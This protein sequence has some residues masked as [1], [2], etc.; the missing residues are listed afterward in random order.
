[1]RPALALLCLATMARAQTASS[2]PAGKWVSNLKFF[3]ENN[4]ERMELNLGGTRL[5]G[6]IGDHVFEG[7]FQPEF[8]N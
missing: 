8:R 2:S 1:M 3:E 5:T 6:K 7:T 4:Y